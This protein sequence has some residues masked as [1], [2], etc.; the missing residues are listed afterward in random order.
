LEAGTTVTKTSVFSVDPHADHIPAP[1]DVSAIETADLCFCAFHRTVM[2]SFGA[3]AHGAASF[4]AVGADLYF[5]L[6][7]PNRKKE[8]KK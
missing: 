3:V 2:F 7:R 5:S 1:G 8:R 6:K 4:A